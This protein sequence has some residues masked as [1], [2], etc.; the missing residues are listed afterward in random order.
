MPELDAL[1]LAASRLVCALASLALAIGWERTRPYRRVPRGRRRARANLGLWGLGAGLVPLLP[2]VAGV[3]AAALA[4]SAGVGLLNW[5]EAPRALGFIA[6][7]LI[8]DALTY[9][10]HRLYHVVPLLWRLHR[11]HHS[12]VYLTVTTGVRFHPL[13]VILSACVRA[14][15]IAVLGADLLGVAAFEALL[16][17]LSQLQHADARLPASI[18]PRL[19]QVLFTPDLHRIHHSTRRDEADSNYGTILTLWDRL[20]RTLRPE[21]RPGA[22]VVGLPDGSLRDRDSLTDLLALPFRPARLAASPTSRPRQE[23][24]A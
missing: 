9:Q 2:G 13:E 23:S 5:A 12:D 8:L 17:L 14:V 20:G 10:L 11:I 18:E 7:V 6:T 22:I 1:A 15:A 19:R 4:G 16:L 24:R 21:P 3:A